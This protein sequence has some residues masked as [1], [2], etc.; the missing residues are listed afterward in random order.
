M[1]GFQLPWQ[2]HASITP[3]LTVLAV[4]MHVGWA[5]L[6]GAAT[7]RLMQHSPRTARAGATLL[8]VLLCLL[9]NEW[10]PSWWLGLAFQTP[11]LILQMLCALYLYQTW[12]TAYRARAAPSEP[13]TLTAHIAWPAV[14]VWSAIALGWLL[15][16]D[17]FAWFDIALYAIGFTPYAML[18]ALLFACLLQLISARSAHSAE[19]RRYRELAAVVLI[20][21]LVHLFTRLPNGNVWDALLDPWL[22]LWAH[23]IMFMRLKRSVFA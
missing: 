9:P 1:I 21:L 4:G 14:L 3:S 5:L 6:L 7:T 2:A 22:W 17:T 19:T 13:D 20:A 23:L 12:R 11:S 16:L 18:A 8:V 15:L 10:S